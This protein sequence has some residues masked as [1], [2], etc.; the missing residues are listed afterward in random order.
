MID[1]ILSYSFLI[2][3]VIGTRAIFKDR[4]SQR[5]RYALWALVLLR[6]LSPGKGQ[7]RAD[8]FTPKQMLIR[9][10]CSVQWEAALQAALEQAALGQDS[11]LEFQT[12]DQEETWIQV[13]LEPQGDRQ[14]AEAIGTIRESTVVFED[15]LK[16]LRTARDD[17]F[18]TVG[19]Y[20][21]YERDQAGL[22]ALANL[23]LKSYTDCEEFW[24]FALA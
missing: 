1:W 17:G 7:V 3:M 23:Y 22:A 4:I 6:L 16:A 13:R 14:Q 21:R 5:L 15:S 19:V 12:M 2:L 18:L 11:E 24:K 8:L 20:D 9:L 10:N